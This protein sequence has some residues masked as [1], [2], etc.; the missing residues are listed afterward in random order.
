MMLRY[1]KPDVFYGQALCQVLVLVKCFYGQFIFDLRGVIDIFEVSNNLCIGS[2]VQDFKTVIIK[3][4]FISFQVD[5]AS[6]F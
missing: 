1:G 3:Y 2:I 6:G 5:Q 4:G